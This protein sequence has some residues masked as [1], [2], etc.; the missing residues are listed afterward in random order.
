MN[1]LLNIQLFA[2]GGGSNLLLSNIEF[3]LFKYIIRDYR[4][5]SINTSIL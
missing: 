2:R 4:I 5:A 1:M 3:D